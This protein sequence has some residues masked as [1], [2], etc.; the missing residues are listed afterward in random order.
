ME[1]AGLKKTVKFIGM[2]TSIRLVDTSE[3]VEP[4][5]SDK[6]YLEMLKTLN[7]EA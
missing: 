4:E 6:E 7:G 3:K 1:F 5:I 2:F